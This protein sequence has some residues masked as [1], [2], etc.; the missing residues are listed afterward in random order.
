[1]VVEPSVE[2]EA[3]DGA[4]L[5]VQV[6]GPDGAPALLLL[7][8]QANDHTW[9]DGLRPA[10]DRDHRTVTFDYRGTGATRSPQDELPARDRAWS[11]ASFADD[12]L[13]VLDALGHERFSVYGTSMGGRVAQMLALAAPERLERLVLACTS[14]GGP[15]AVERGRDVRRLLGQPHSTA[16]TRG[17]L[18]LFYTAAWTGKS[19]LL[20]DP[21]MTPE[22][23]RAH[24]RASAGHD[25][26]QRLAEITA[27][28]LVLHGS[29]DLMVP[30]DNAPL[31]ASRLPDATLHL[32]EGGRHGFFD[33][34]ADE[35]TPRVLAFLAG[36]ATDPDDDP[37]EVLRRWEGAG[38]VWRVLAETRD[39]LTV[40]L[41]TCDGGEEVSRLT[42]A[43][44]GLADFVRAHREP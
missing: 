44:P 25:A 19:R 38:A 34:F 32:H 13:A 37:V 17:V 24:L 8:G 18:A 9:W 28:T 26:S 10:F 2:I 1:M 6:G 11:T 20:G 14:A 4:L 7:P 39:G 12:A 42:S 31:I 23:A 22:A 41:F 15:D 40:G 21:T 16:R 43:D 3:P 30:T 27:P 36:G 5:S 35:V 33:E 29:E